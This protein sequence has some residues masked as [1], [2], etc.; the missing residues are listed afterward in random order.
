MTGESLAADRELSSSRSLST[1]RRVHVV[2]FSRPTVLHLLCELGMESSEL[3]P[4]VMLT[5]RIT[6]KRTSVHGELD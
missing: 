3:S 6:P 2:L 1:A 4:L 5:Q